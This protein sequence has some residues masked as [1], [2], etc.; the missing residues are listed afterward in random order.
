MFSA[1]NW[2]T[3]LGGQ[4]LSNPVTRRV[5]RL[6]LTPIVSMCGVIR[7]CENS[8]SHLLLY[9]IEWNVGHKQIGQPASQIYKHHKRCCSVRFY[10]ICKLMNMNLRSSDHD[11]KIKFGTF[12]RR[13]PNISPVTGVRKNLF[14]TLST[15]KSLEFGQKPNRGR[16]SGSPHPFIT[17]DH[18]MKWNNV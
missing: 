9:Q 2:Q 16:L 7:P 13:R 4:A 14:G 15:E 3:G 17:I 18:M 5:Q 8:W 12:C 10:G 1:R 6:C 11:L